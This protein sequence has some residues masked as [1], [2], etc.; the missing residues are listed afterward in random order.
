M[1]FVIFGFLFIV[2]LCGCDGYFQKETVIT[3]EDKS[4]VIFCG[5]ANCKNLLVFKSE[6]DYASCVS[7]GDQTCER[8]KNAI[9]IDK[10]HPDYQ[11]YMLKWEVCRSNIGVKDFH[12]FY[13]WYQ[14]NK[15]KQFEYV[16]SETSFES[17][18]P[19]TQETV[20][21]NPTH[22]IKPIYEKRSKMVPR[23]I[24][25]TLSYV[26]ETSE[27]LVG[28]KIT[29]SNKNDVIIPTGTTSCKITVTRKIGPITYWVE[30]MQ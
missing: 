26:S 15:D 4:T 12:K 6:K 17:S 18:T 5:N 7:T 23:H 29:K 27:D 28:F 8:M 22:T 9:V 19:T 14:Q 1:K 13:S 16:V 3:K 25:R 30:N 10:N 2:I 11:Y 21:E 20:I 24:G